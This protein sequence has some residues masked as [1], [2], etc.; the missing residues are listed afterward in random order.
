VSPRALKL[1][2]IAMLISV[3]YLHPLSM[4]FHTVIAARI[5]SFEGNFNE[6]L[7]QTEFTNRYHEYS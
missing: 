5:L 7:Q 3:P 6:C 1:Q 2:I 4:A